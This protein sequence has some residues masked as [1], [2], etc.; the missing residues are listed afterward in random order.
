M[1]FPV[2]VEQLS[3]HFNKH[4]VVHQLTFQVA[5]GQILGFLG[6][7]GAGKSTTMKMITGYLRPSQGT[8]WVGGYNVHK[9]PRQAKKNIGYLPEHNPLYL[10]M[11]VHEY[12][13]FMGRI[14]GL[15][16]KE[17]VVRA[18]ELVAR[19]GIAQMQNK[20][21]RTLS[22][23][24]RQRVGLAQALMHDPHVLILDEPTTGLDPNQLREIRALIKEVS[25]D[26][27]VILSTHIM[28]E[29]EALCDQVLIVDQGKMVLHD[30]LAQ[31]AAQRH[32]QLVVE[33]KEPISEIMLV[34]IKGVQRVQ[35]LSAYRYLIDARSDQDIRASLFH[36]AQE[37]ALTLLGMEQQRDS[38]EDVFQ[39][40]TGIIQDQP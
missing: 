29:V 14:R 26:K 1:N 17:C 37:N 32:G 4:I 28:Q 22:K 16:R 27:A 39:Q 20:K 38:L 19:C 25:S 31:L 13:R 11:Y 5:R 21:L 34:P 8:V 7:N 15:Q 35:A 18:K 24:F 6:P 36:F 9:H 3:K 23:G 40:L 12:L 10:D 2:A 30:T 33:F